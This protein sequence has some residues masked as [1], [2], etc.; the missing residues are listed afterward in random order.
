MTRHRVLP[1]GTTLQ[2]RPP[3]V[4]SGRL[5][6]AAGDVREGQNRP[7]VFGRSAELPPDEREFNHW[8]PGYRPG[9]GQVCRINPPRFS[10]MYYLPGR[11]RRLSAHPYYSAFAPADRGYRTALMRF[12][13][14]I[15][16]DPEFRHLVLDRRDLWYPWYNTLAPLKGKGPWYWRVGYYLKGL[17]KTS[18][19]IQLRFVFKQD[20]RPQLLD[21]N[22][23][24]DREQPYLDDLFLSWEAWRPT[25]TP[26]EFA[27]GLDPDQ[28][29]LSARM[30]SGPQRFL[31]DSLRGAVWDCYPLNIP[32]ADAADMSDMDDACCQAGDEDSSSDQDSWESE[33]EEIETRADVEAEPE[34]DE[35]LTCPGEPGY[36][37]GVV[38]FAVQDLLETKKA[39][40][41]AAAFAVKPEDVKE[42]QPVWSNN[43]CKA[44]VNQDIQPPGEVE[45]VDTLDGGSIV[46]KV[47]ERELVLERTWSEKYEFFF[48]KSPLDKEN[49]TLF[50]EG[51]TISV[52]NGTG[53]A[54]IGH[55][56]G[57]AKAPKKP[58][59]VLPLPLGSFC[60][61]PERGH[62]LK[63]T[64]KEGGD[65]KIYLN[66]FAFTKGADDKVED[67]VGIY[68]VLPDKGCFFGACSYTIPAEAIALIPDP[69]DGMYLSMARS[70]D[71]DISNCWSDSGLAV[72][73]T[74]VQSIS[75]AEP[76]GG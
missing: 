25:N 56:E 34:G 55:F 44:F 39:A 31:N 30:Y 69:V 64:W 33:P 1:A 13:F 28:Y 29:A 47:N 42:R 27:K 52:D 61:T 50:S 10:W 63:V 46:V 35:E 21:E 6:G 59:T 76:D 74:V 4:N 68:C 22:N 57:S 24:L 70:N 12:R 36:F 9:D 11:S 19:H 62:S 66:L 14:Q 32:D 49:E 41:L 37:G 38:V 26:W 58:E 75:F 15:A 60:E 65:E 17:A 73:W 18:G 54:D 7:I 71:A 2:H 45:P 51:D 40:N 3:A 48:Y 53:G 16:A 67:T 23:Q 8:H 43:E 20:H 5:A 72:T